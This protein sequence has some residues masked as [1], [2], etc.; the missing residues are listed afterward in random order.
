MKKRLNQVAAILGVILLGLMGRMS[1]IQLLGHGDLAHAAAAQ[2]L[3]A[4]EGANSRGLIYDRNQT[5]LVG[6]NREY[7]FIIRQKQF[8][9]E[10]MNALSAMEAEEI[11]NG[12]NGY[13]VFAVKKY[14]KEL[15]Q[16][17]IRNSSAY[18]IEA[19]RRY[20]HSQKA[21][22]ILGYVN[23][24]DSS[25]AAGIELMCDEELSLLNKRIFTTADVLGNIVPGRGLVV[26]TA[27]EEDSYVKKGIVT[28][29]DA[30]LQGAVETIL[31]ST[32]KE[33]AIVV[34]K[35]DTGEIVASAS[36]PDFDP[37]RVGQYMDSSTSE[38]VNKVTQGEYPPGS[39]F[40]IA[41]AAAALQQGITP[42]REFFCQ[43]YM[44]INGR[45]IKCKTGGQTGHGAITMKEAFAQSCNSAFIQLGQEL[46]ADKILNMAQKLGLGKKTLCEYPGEKDGNLMTVRQSSGAAIA[47]LSIGQGETLV[48]PLQAA[49]M[50]NIIAAGG[51][52]TGV[53]ILQEEIKKSSG[54]ESQVLQP[55]IAKRLMEM[56]DQTMITGSGKG[57]LDIAGHVPMAG[58][59]G[60]A[61]SYMGNKE[62]VHGW[63]TGF[64][65]AE[66]PEYTITVF[67][68]EGES[69][70]QSAGPL[71]AQTARYL[72]ESGSFEQPIHF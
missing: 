57:L 53:H 69:G 33:G 22:H 24:Q 58:K 72:S 30:G 64:V 42:E 37:S 29:L 48:T 62:V 44:S 67:I 14:D 34:L 11:K 31:R 3:I 41:V 27:M 70:S 10:A 71:F 12:D 50:T 6:N 68:Q 21:V 2:Q 59:T 15:G 56:M 38:L 32:D 49:H 7:I 35:T 25:G 4:L 55:A 45:N 13:R 19:G 66:N 18:V 26:S 5:P 43:G 52:D 65:P 17:L 63:M 61:E 36:T 28:T 9:G 23:P 54:K 8:D 20:S 51:K 47:N 46:G 16:R 39:I 1:Y 40:K 60:S